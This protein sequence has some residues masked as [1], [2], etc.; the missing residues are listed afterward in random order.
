MA[1]VHDAREAAAGHEAVIVSHQLPIWT[2]RLHVEGRSFLHDPR[3]RQCTLCSLTSLHFV[4]DRVTQVSYTEPAGDLI[5]VADRTAHV[6]GRQRP[7][8]RRRPETLLRVARWCRCS[9][10]CRVQRPPGQRRPRLRAGRSATVAAGRRRRAGATRSRSPA[11]RCTASRSTS[12]T[13]AARSSCS[14]CGA[15]GATRAAR[16]PRCWSRPRGSS[17]DQARVRRA[18]H[19][20]RRHRTGARLRARVRASPTRPSTTTASPLLALRAGTP[21]PR[22]PDHD[23]PRR[24]RAASRR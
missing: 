23:R 8:R 2:T 15:R 21:P 12:P 10:G 14:T 3:K 7:P 19:P 1:A 4:G 11:S 5:P 6:L 22:R 24:R 20:R 9:L 13:C 17:A 16:R 18:R